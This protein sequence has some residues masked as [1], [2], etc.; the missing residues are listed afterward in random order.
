M[1]NINLP[2]Y[3]FGAVSELEAS[4]SGRSEPLT[5]TYTLAKLSHL[6]NIMDVCCLNSD[7]SDF[8]GYGW[9][10]AKDYAMKVDA[11]IVNPMHI[12]RVANICKTNP[13]N[14]DS[15]RTMTAFSYKTFPTNKKHH[16]RT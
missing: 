4:L 1:E 14:V 7:S 16:C 9:T 13:I 6:K 3:T 12:N 10:I 11:S 8:V 15:M 2:L 5:A